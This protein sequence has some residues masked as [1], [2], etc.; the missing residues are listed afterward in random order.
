MNRSVLFATITI[1][2]CAAVQAEEKPVDF[3]DEAFRVIASAPQGKH[4]DHALNSLRRQDYGYRRRPPQF[5]LDHTDH[6]VGDLSVVYRPGKA[7]GADKVGFIG[8][9]WNGK[10][11]LTQDMAL[12]FHLKTTGTGNPAQWTAVLVDVPGKTARATLDGTETQGAWKELKLPVKSFT[13]EEGFDWRAVR[14]V[15]FEAAFGADSEL[16]FDGV[17]F[18]GPTRTIG[19]TD[20]T[21]TQRMQEAE[22]NREFRVMEGYRLNG[23]HGSRKSLL[24]FRLMY[25]NQ[26]L[27]KANQLLLDDIE[28]QLEKKS[29]WCLITTQA[30]CRLY[31]MFSNRL[32]KFP[33]R[34]TPEVEKRLLEA[35]WER[36]HHK[37][38]IHW[39]RKS[40]WW[41]DGS[42]NHDLNAK[43][44][45][46]LSSRIFMNEPDYKDRI[47]R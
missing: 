3:W 5:E 4:V 12:A 14:L 18:E 29:L 7:N 15:E 45:N 10:W 47:Y 8:N 21:V 13:A 9:L 46:L 36:T 1:A 43:V 44:C 17:R 19:I 20:K 28:L 42:H 30:Y 32:G 35:I 33:G 40:T 23:P 41:M 26:D 24:A 38:D 37:N 34:M 31:Y 16:R 11:D 22:E 25:L 2:C 6:Q 39:A 27:E